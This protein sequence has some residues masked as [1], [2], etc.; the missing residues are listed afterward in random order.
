MADDSIHRGSDRQVPHLLADVLMTQ[1]KSTR[2]S[3]ITNKRCVSSQPARWFHAQLAIALARRRPARS[4]HRRV[5]RDHSACPRPLVGTSRPGQ[6]PAGQ[7]RCQRSGCPVPRGPEAGARLDRSDRHPGSGLGR[8]GQSRGSTPPLGAS[9]EARTAQRPGPLPPGPGSRT[10][11]GQS[12]S[13]I[14]HLNEAIRLQPDNVPM[15][16]QT[17][18]ILATSPDPAIRDGA[19]AVELARRAIQLS[20]RPRGARL[21]C[22]RRRAGRNRGSSPR[23]SRQP[24]KRR[25]WPCSAATQRWPTP[26]RS[27]RASIARAC[28][29][30]SRLRLPAEHAPPDAAE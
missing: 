8:R 22:A 10:I 17:A 23:P 24:S 5:A 18:W 12:Q 19:R 30:A 28:R 7:R 25:R 21:R 9:L 4:S 3:R 13:A 26:S 2:R 15:L 20:K 11:V 27:G 29:I 1:G 14:A 6:C 16:W